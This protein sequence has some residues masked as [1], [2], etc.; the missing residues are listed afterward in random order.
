MIT[1]NSRNNDSSIGPGSY[2]LAIND[3]N[4]VFSFGKDKR[5]INNDSSIGPAKYDS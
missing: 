5:F 3:I 2:E 1:L 4:R